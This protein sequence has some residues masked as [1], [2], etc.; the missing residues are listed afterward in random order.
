MEN[1]TVSKDDMEELNSFSII[2]KFEESS[3]KRHCFVAESA[4]AVVQWIE[5][6]QSSSYERRREQLILLQ[7][8]IRNK[9][10]VDPLRTS[11]FEH[12]P[13]YFLESRQILQPNLIREAPEPPVRKGKSGRVGTP[14]NSGFTSH[15]GIENW[16]KYYALVFSQNIMFLNFRF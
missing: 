6:L 7:I 4:R 11:A 12:N 1:F 5:A 9:T 8:K 10:G 13:S 14:K 2:F 3:E 16:E 15:I